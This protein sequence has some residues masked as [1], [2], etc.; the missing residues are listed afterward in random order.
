[1]SLKS[2]SRTLVQLSALLC[3]N[4]WAAE[5]QNL[6]QSIKLADG[7]NFTPTL[8][9]SERYDDNFREREKDVDAS[10][11]TSIAP[12]FAI[13]AKGNKASY[14]LSYKADTDIFHSSSKDNNTDHY[15][16]GTASLD[17][18]VRNRVRFDAGYEK[19]EET[20]SLDQQI[21]NDKYTRSHVGGLY[22]YG[23]R[24]A[25]GNIE[26]SGDYSQLRY[27]NSG[28][29]NNDKERDVVALASTF[30]VRVAP[31][32]RLLVEG[33]Y[34]DFDYVSN[35]RLNSVGMALLGGVEWEATA[36]TSGS[37]KIGGER[38]NYDDSE[39]GAKSGSLWEVGAS[40]KP[41]TYSTFSLKTRHHLDEGTDGASTIDSLS[42]T[43]DWEHEWLTRFST[44]VFYTHGD[45]QYRNIERE[46]KY[47]A[48]GVRANYQA[49]RWLGFSLGYNFK[50]NDSTAINESFERNV[51]TIGVNA[52]L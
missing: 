7:L 33:R 14:E 36:K 32:T 47:N 26:F 39:V 30:Y 45:G 35:T 41:R 4:A 18:N 37:I 10:W 11:I 23:A 50:K 6:P 12:R 43:V 34:N 8:Q 51:Y 13:G 40:Y 5:P 44:K 24:T 16:D 29:L 48:Y 49:R 46:D 28:T 21:E 15:L 2:H 42:T 9:V 17:F 52:S 22:T 31:R 20:A 38:K 27:Q 3:A 19:V 25:T 1:M